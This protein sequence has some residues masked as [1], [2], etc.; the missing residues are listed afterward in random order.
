M[1]I[2]GEWSE[3]F[4]M[5]AAASIFPPLSSMS[6]ETM[7]L[8]ILDTAERALDLPLSYVNFF[9]DIFRKLSSREASARP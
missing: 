8:S 2:I 4:L 5:E 9:F 6:C 1:I 3:N 7:N